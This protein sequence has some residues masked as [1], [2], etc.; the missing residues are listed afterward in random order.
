MGLS[1]KWW[2]KRYEY[3]KRRTVHIHRCFYLDCDPDSIKSAEIV[4][5]VHMVELCMNKYDS[6]ISLL[7]EELVSPKIVHIL[8]NGLVT[9]N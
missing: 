9:N 8:M 7:V 5:K 6:G 3:Q 1:C 2:W 4:S